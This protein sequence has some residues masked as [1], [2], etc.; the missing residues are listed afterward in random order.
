MPEIAGGF[1]PE[2]QKFWISKIQ[3]MDWEACSPCESHAMIMATSRREATTTMEAHANSS[4]AV[5]VP[6]SL[7]GPYSMK[8]A[9]KILGESLGRYLSGNEAER[10]KELL[11]VKGFLKA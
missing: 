5:V 1:V 8:E 11:V 6:G 7:Q 9:L 3:G 2:E 4:Q 10:T